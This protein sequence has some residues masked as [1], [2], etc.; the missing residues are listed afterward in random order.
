M[1]ID[2]KEKKKKKEK[3]TEDWL[4]KTINDAIEQCAEVAIQKALDECFKNFKIQ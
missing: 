3:E 1:R 2:S 4:F